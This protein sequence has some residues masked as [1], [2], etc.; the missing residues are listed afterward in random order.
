MRSTAASTIAGFRCSPSAGP[1]RCTPATSPELLESPVVI[2]PPLASVLSAFGTLVTP[3]RLDLGRG[4]LARLSVLD[5]A[6]VKSVLTELVTDARGG[7]ASAGCKPADITLRFGADMR[8]FGQ[9]N[10]VTTWFDADPRGRHGRRVGARDVRD[11]IREALSP[12]AS[13]RGRRGRELAPDRHRPVARARDSA[14]VLSRRARQGEDRAQGAL[15]R[16]RRRHAGLSAPRT[17]AGSG[18]RGPAII[19]ERETT[20]IILPG[21]RAKVHATGCIMA[22]KAEEPGSDAHGRHRARDRLE[23][24]DQHRQRAGEGAAAH[25]LHPDRAR[26]W[27][28]RQRAVRPA[29]PHGGA[30]GHRHA[31]PHQFARRRRQA[32]R[33]GVSRR[34]RSKPATCSSPTIRGSRP[35]TSSTSP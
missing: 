17:R 7:L 24:P 30:G 15:Q 35:G 26:G 21:W 1:G 6:H 19:E 28:S 32:L 14:A 22:T 31:G 5:W 3:P 27:R 25:R 11:R 8:Y 2:Y 18:H 13:R 10:E 34:R 33:R 20:I 4:A 23:Q 29:G 9:Q 16:R 12:A